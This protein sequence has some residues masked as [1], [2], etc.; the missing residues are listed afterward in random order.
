MCLIAFEIQF[1]AALL[2]GFSA[3]IF[4][5]FSYNLTA[6]LRQV[7]KNP[8]PESASELHR[9][10]ERRLLAK[11]AP[12]FSETGCHLVNLTDSYGR[13]LGFLDQSCYFFIQVAPQ[14]YTRS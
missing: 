11:L 10:S 5:T 4:S 14:F 3:T 12:T 7:E 9:P 2:S 13:V 1:T 8:W 6:D